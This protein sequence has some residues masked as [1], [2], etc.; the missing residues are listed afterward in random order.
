MMPLGTYHLQQDLAAEA[1]AQWS[2]WMKYLFTC[3]TL[4]V[5]GSFTIPADKVERWQRQMN[6]DYSGLSEKEQISDIEMVNR[7]L[8]ILGEHLS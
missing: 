7:Y 4:N 1:H 6:T 3:G 2:H 8:A 5:D